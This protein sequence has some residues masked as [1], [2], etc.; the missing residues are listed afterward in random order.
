MAVNRDLVGAAAA[1]VT[2]GLSTGVCALLVPVI[3]R[4]A[5][6]RGERRA[7]DVPVTSENGFTMIA[8]DRY[9]LLIAAMTLLINIVNTTGEYLFGRYTIEQAQLLFPGSDAAVMAAREQFVGA[10]Y[11]KLY[12][13]VNLIGFLLQTF[14]V[15]RVLK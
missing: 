10:T 15:A 2:A 13:T 9:L 12:S 11:S 3:Y 1:V 4:H 6:A 14:V 7:K 8:K 5:P